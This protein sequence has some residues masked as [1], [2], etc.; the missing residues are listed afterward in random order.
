MQNYYRKL[1]QFTLG[2]VGALTLTD[3]SEFSLLGSGV[4]QVTFLYIS[5]YKINIFIKKEAQPKFIEKNDFVIEII[6][7][8]Q[9]DAYH[10]RNGFVRMITSKYNDEAAGMGED[11]REEFLSSLTTFKSIFPSK[12]QIKK[13]EVLRFEKK[14]T[15][16]ICTFKDR[17]LGIL[18]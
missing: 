7:Q 15:A 3:D 12:M 1:T 4:R 9:T 14:D 17:F 2:I 5:V 13:D 18:G 8:R 16:L 10:L 6:P 11:E